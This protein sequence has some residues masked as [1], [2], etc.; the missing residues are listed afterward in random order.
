MLYG[1]RGDPA[2]IIKGKYVKPNSDSIYPYRN[3]GGFDMIRSG[4]DKFET[5]EQFKQAKETV[6]KLDLDGLLVIGDDD[7]NTNACLLAENFRSKS[8]KAHVIDGP[9]RNLMMPLRCLMSS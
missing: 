8:M 2:G 5:P 1:F 9:P 3:Q 6:Q 4:R 7:S